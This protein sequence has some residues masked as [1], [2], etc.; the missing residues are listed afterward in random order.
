M[1]KGVVYVTRDPR[2]VVGR[3]VLRAV[4][5]DGSKR[6]AFEVYQ[7]QQ[8]E[9]EES[10]EE[11]SEDCIVTVSR[12]YAGLVASACRRL[13]YQFATRK[14]PRKRKISQGRSSTKK[15]RGNEVIILFSCGV[16]CMGDGNVGLY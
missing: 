7:Q 14:V 8:E 2:V 11:L 13:S 12:Y 15:R 5:M 4:D 10:S 9:S 3:T 1:T 6:S 16:G